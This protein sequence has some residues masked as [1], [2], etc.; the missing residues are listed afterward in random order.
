MISLVDVNV[1]VHVDVDGFFFGRKLYPATTVH[2]HDHV[3]VHG[4]DHRR[5]G[6]SMEPGVMK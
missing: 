1:D 3:N 5:K 4:Y 6:R 2:E